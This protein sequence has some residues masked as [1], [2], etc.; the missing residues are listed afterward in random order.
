[1]GI[2]IAI[3]EQELKKKGLN[4]EKVAER[5]GMDA[6]TLYR[7]LKAGGEKITVGEVH[8][9]I[10]ILDLSREQAANIFLLDNSQ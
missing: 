3:F 10:D 6:S 4:K 9:I 5:L 2:D 7:K 1:M 8:G